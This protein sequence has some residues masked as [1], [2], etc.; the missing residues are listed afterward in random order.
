VF[1]AHVAARPDRLRTASGT[2]EFSAVGPLARQ[3]IEADTDDDVL[4]PLRALIQADGAVILMGVGLTR[5]TLLHLAE[6]EAGRRP[7]IRWARRPDGQVARV[8]VG[9]CSDGFDSLA[10]AL[11]PAEKRRVVG[12]SLWRVFD[13]REAVRVASAA[14]RQEPAI[15]RCGKAVCVECDDAIAGGP[16]E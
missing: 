2:G 15:T 11:R 5:M 9:G 6:V 13:A 16:V 7:F 3:L 1:S 14:I 8:R 10:D 4:G 12:R